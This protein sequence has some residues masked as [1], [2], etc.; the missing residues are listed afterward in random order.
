MRG[1][2]ETRSGRDKP[3]ILLEGGKNCVTEEEGITTCNFKGV[4]RKDS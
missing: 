1:E 2:N 3:R 4:T